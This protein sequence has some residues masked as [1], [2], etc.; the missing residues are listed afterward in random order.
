MM[1]NRGRI[2]CLTHLEDK[3]LSTFTEDFAAILKNE[4]SEMNS[5]AAGSSILSSIAQLEVNVVCCFGSVKQQMPQE[6]T[7][8][9]SHSVNMV[10]TCVP[11]GIELSR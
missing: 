10:I 8:K 5:T 4:L 9:V 2:V 11:A 1:I 6:I 3:D 7:K